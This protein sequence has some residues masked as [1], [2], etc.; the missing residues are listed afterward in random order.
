VTSTARLGILGQFYLDR[1]VRGWGDIYEAGPQPAGPADLDLLDLHARPR[2]AAR[3]VPGLEL[4]AAGQLSRA[5]AGLAEAEMAFTVV[6]AR[7]DDASDFAQCAGVSQD[8]AQD[9]VTAA[10]QTLGPIGRD[11]V[12]DDIS[13][14]WDTSHP[15]DL[16]DQLADGSEPAA[17][18]E[19]AWQARAAKGR[20]DYGDAAQAWLRARDLLDVSNPLR[21]GLDGLITSLRTADGTGQYVTWD[22]RLL[23]P[24]FAGVTLASATASAAAADEAKSPEAP[25]RA[26]GTEFPGAPARRRAT[27]RGRRATGTGITPGT[28]PGTRASA[29]NGGQGR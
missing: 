23:A 13:T 11:Y 9:L 26:G 25:G 17:F 12:S 10:A 28:G 6:V 4:H 16:A 29:A 22:G 7:F 27:G 15:H 18:W 20:G 5:G 3:P 21:D 1:E 14:S 24:N 19:M 8:Q 2:P